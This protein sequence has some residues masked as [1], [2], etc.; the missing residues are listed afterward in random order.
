MGTLNVYYKPILGN[1]NRTLFT[2]S[3]NR[4]NVWNQGQ[5]TVQSL[6]PYNIMFEAIKGSSYLS[7]LAID[8]IKILPGTCMKQTTPHSTVPTSVKP[9]S[10]RTFYKQVT[11]L[12]VN[13]L[14]KLVLTIVI[15]YVALLYNF[16]LKLCHIQ[17]VQHS[18]I[19]K[20]HT[21]CTAVIDYKLHVCR[22]H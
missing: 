17:V 4:G 11:N 19:K 21:G 8:D 14:L 22:V 5:A 10:E 18:L 13:F 2:M 12:V 3:G 15:V 1:S 6:K 16:S 7:D 9:L 20:S